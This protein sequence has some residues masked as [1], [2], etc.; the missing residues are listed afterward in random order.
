MPA[1]DRKSF[2]EKIFIKSFVIIIAILL[3]WNCS[4]ESNPLTSEK[5]TLEGTWTEEFIW[6]S[7]GILI[8]GGG[9]F[10]DTLMLKKTTINFQGNNFEIKILPPNRIL[11]V[12][13]DSIVV[14]V[15]SDT[16]YCGTYSISSDTLKFYVGQQENPKLFRYQLE[17]DSL[18]IQQFSI[19]DSSGFFLLTRSFLW[20]NTAYKNS[21]VFVRRQ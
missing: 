6:N 13:N 12:I 16:I 18:H 11:T 10:E 7:I 2:M 19:V 4:K 8:F 21:G 3:A 1:L 14:T 20:G 9:T 5:E 15:S 17:Q